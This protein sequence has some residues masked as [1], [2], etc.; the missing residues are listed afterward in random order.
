MSLATGSRLG[1]YEILSPLGAGGMGEVYRARDA[2][3]GR[4]VAIKVLPERLAADPESLSRFEREARAV[5]ALSH[6]NI[7]AIHDFGTDGGVTYAVMEL[8]EGQTLRAALSGGALPVRKATDIAREIARGLA[9]AHERGIVHRDLKPEN[10]FV[11]RDGR[12]KILDF[13]LAKSVSV[14]AAPAETRSPTVSSYTE[15][16]TVLGTVSYMSP[17]Q[18]RGEPLDSRSDIF[19]FG[20]VLY[21]MLSGKRAFEKGTVAE[22]M[23][24]ILREEPPEIAGSARAIPPGLERVLRHCLEKSPESRFQSSSDAA[25]AL[26]SLTAFSGSAEAP[27]SNGRA[28]QRRSRMAEPLVFAAAGALIAASIAVPVAMQ[29]Q[30]SRLPAP[31]PTVRFTIAPPRDA[32]FEGMLALSPDGKRLAFVAGRAFGQSA[33]YVRPLDS[34]EAR[35]LEGTDDATFPFWSPDGRFLAFF[36]AGKLKKIDPSGGLPQVLC[37]APSARG[38][39]WSTTGTILFSINAGGE[40][41]RV[42]ELGGK[43]VALEQLVPRGSEWFRWPAFLPDGRHFLYFRLSLDPNVRGIY[44]GSLGSAETIR[45]AFGDAG[46]V[47]APPGVLFY[48]VG[49]RLMM[50]PFDADRLRVGGEATPLVENVWWDTL[51]TLATAF[52]VSRNGV[53]AYQTGGLASTRLLWLDRSGHELGAAG[54]AGA[55]IEPAL[56][57]DGKWIAVTRGEPDSGRISVWTIDAERGSLARVSPADQ[58]AAAAPIWSPDGRSIAYALYPSGGAYAKDARG[59]GSPKLLF[60]MSTFGSLDDWSRDG[61]FIF[62]D[63]IDFRTFRTDLAAQDLSSGQARRISDVTWAESG[64]RLSPDGRWLAFSSNESGTYELVVRSFPGGGERRQVSAGG[65]TQPVWR[66]DGKELF[67]ISP[68]GEVM[69]A[70]VRA[71][72]ALEIGKPRVLFATHILPLVEARNNYDVTADGQRFLVNSR[73]PEDA[74]LPITVLSP[75][76]SGAHP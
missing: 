8:L 65:G 58:F 62:Y 27:R 55:Y 21:E 59:E 57:P 25:F 17:E 14:G 46:A 70:D 22:T 44:V 73:R 61:R 6:P 1:P 5:A 67:Y 12:V 35:A 37:D 56:S 16:G 75:W 40:M 66:G 43:P 33:L 15:P 7:L 42:P 76:A 20:A 74:S 52:S 9:A 4:D 2:K 63:L 31:L 28:V 34:L 48:R 32:S 64:A 29:R 10:I 11:T 24:A 53:M 51:S 39:A 60:R 50:Q 47:Y 23:T 18:V 41:D 19:S 38:G 30:R 69:A 26:E 49:D 72:P 68:D 45:V 3:L 71:D 54:P 36:A 13:G